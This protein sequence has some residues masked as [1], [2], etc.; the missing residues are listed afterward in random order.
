MYIS[1]FLCLIILHV[2][3]SESSLESERYVWS[4][5]YMDLQTYI[6]PPL[7][8]RG[9]SHIT[10]VRQLQVSSSSRTTQQIKFHLKAVKGNLYFYISISAV[11]TMA[12]ESE[13]VSERYVQIKRFQLQL[14]VKGQTSTISHSMDVFVP[15]KSD[16]YLKLATISPGMRQLPQFQPCKGNNLKLLMQ[17][18]RYKL[19][20]NS[21][22]SHTDRKILYQ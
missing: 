21:F 22:L 7:G 5:K 2:L 15:I 14:R 19:R 20:K 9:M 16:E 4:I 10:E 1:D 17:P 3:P 18:Q 12:S 13:L 6:E 8:I 11:L